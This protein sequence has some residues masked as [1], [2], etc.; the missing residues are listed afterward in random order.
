M[1]ESESNKSI[2]GKAKAMLVLDPSKGLENQTLFWLS[3]VIPVI[4]ALGL[5]ILALHEYSWSLSVDGYETF[6][7]ANALPI[8]ISSLAIPLGVLFGRLHGTK[9]TALQISEA[10]ARN[11]AELYLAHYSHFK[12]HFEDSHRYEIELRNQKKMSFDCRRL[13]RNIYPNNGLINGIKDANPEPLLDVWITVVTICQ[14]L[15]NLTARI[16]DSTLSPSILSESSRKLDTEMF[17]TFSHAGFKLSNNFSMDLFQFEEIQLIISKILEETLKAKDFEPSFMRSL[18][19]E[20]L[21]E[22][23][24]SLEALKR[25]IETNQSE[26]ANVESSL[27]SFHSMYSNI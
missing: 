17:F 11:R 18:E 9:Q 5:S 2:F 14:Y 7:K 4:F 23:F 22:A 26:V 21:H 27:A 25:V 19:N 8:G 13:Y 10:Q 6:L 24:S 15:E 16:N 12:D 3:V 1:D 20:T